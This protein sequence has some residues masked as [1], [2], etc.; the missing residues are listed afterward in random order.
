[1]SV[2]VIG[3][4]AFILFGLV[5][6]LTA[7]T[8]EIW[9]WR[10]PLIRQLEDRRVVWDQEEAWVPPQA[11]SI[12]DYRKQRDMGAKIT[13][14]H[15]L[16]DLASEIKQRLLSAHLRA[17]IVTGVGGLLIVFAT[18][19]PAPAAAGK[20][21]PSA[22]PSVVD[23]VGQI[24]VQFLAKYTVPISATALIVES[25]ALILGLMDQCRKYETLLDPAR[26]GA[27]RRKARSV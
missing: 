4:A 13:V 11:T 17:A 9:F 15:H 23:D 24:V 20:G 22:K 12:S 26:V 7:A 10:L 1:M 6:L 14:T 3:V 21:S 2:A 19:Q 27:R 25:M 18:A 5:P 8:M 16:A